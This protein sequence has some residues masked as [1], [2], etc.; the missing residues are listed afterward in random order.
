M[1]SLKTSRDFWDTDRCY[2]FNMDFEDFKLFFETEILDFT[3]D[4]DFIDTLELFEMLLWVDVNF[5]GFFE[6]FLGL[7]PAVWEASI[8][9]YPATVYVLPFFITF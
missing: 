9:L 4:F 1:V 8:G 5:L 6:F 7:V 3:E 2:W